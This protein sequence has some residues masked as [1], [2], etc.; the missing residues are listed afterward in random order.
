MSRTG[1]SAEQAFGYLVENCFRVIVA[2]SA[3]I[4]V[5][6]D[7][8]YA[9]VITGRDASLLFHAAGLLRDAILTRQTAGDIRVVAA[10]KSVAFLRH[11][12]PS[13]DLL[14]TPLDASVSFSSIASF[15]GSIGQAPY[16]AAN[17]SLEGLAIIERV[18]G[19]VN[20]SC[21]FGA[22]KNTGM[23]ANGGSEAAEKYGYGALSLDEGVRAL[24]F[25]ASSGGGVFPS[26]GRMIVTPIE[27]L[28]P[29]T[30]L[31]FTHHFEDV[32]L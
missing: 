21:A 20:G 16:A 30:F 15:F 22:W 27:W 32:C 17:A 29:F 23:A 2:I 5:A 28:T 14:G 24:A 7:A 4:S 19:A 9:R 11:F 25:A 13:R 12:R 31:R 3:D 10:P 8:F 18:R 1:R 6:E 26:E